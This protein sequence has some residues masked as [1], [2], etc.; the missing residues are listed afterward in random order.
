[1]RAVPEGVRVAQILAE[2][3]AAAAGQPVAKV[4]SAPQPSI[5]HQPIPTAAAA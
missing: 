5:G 2:A 1:M 4:A 3:L